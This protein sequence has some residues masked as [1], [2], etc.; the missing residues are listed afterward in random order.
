[1]YRQGDILIVKVGSI[2]ADARLL[3]HC[4]IA[5]GEATGHRHRIETGAEQLR[6]DAGD[7]FIRV[8]TPAADLVH[9]EHATITLPGPALYRVLHQ[10][11][12]MPAEGPAAGTQ[13]HVLVRD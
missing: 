5:L 7:Q 4:V 10:R 9:E 12:F 11:E 8:L 6:T 3:D 2:P 1:M 13:S